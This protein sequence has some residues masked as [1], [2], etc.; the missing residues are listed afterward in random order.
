[1][2]LPRRPRAPTL[3]NMTAPSASRGL[4]AVLL[5]ACLLGFAA[6]FVKWAVAGG[7]TS[8]TVGFYRML[9][10]VPGAY[11]LARLHGG[12]PSLGAGPGRLWALA[13]GA[14]FFL[15]LWGWHASMHHTS[16][17]NATRPSST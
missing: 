14:A 1:M 8:F 3:G 10:A 9:F 11:V 6:I 2:G 7:A 4:V 5:G 16:A 17:A 15:D 12:G 13:A